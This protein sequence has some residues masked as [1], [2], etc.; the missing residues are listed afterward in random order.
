MPLRFVRAQIVRAITLIASGSLLV[1]CAPEPESKVKRWAS[2]IPA[3]KPVEPPS[4]DPLDEPIPEPIDTAPPEAPPPKPLAPT[5]SCK[6][7]VDRACQTLGV[8]SDECRE[9]RD[10]VPASEP[11]AIR[12]ACARVVEEDAELL[13][14]GGLAEGKS[15]CRL[16]VRTTCQ[17]AG[18][19][20]EHCAE[21]KKASRMLTAA[22]RTNACIG[23][24]LLFELKRALN[25]SGTE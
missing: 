19:K 9:V 11:P 1:A 5:P 23:E 17:R 20:S 4:A 24:L 3:N 8:H 12:A 22:K 7:V 14:P 18:Y 15:P 25:P 2:E 21:A 6:L 13:Q 16:L 10:L